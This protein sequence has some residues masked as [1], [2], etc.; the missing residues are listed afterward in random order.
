MGLTSIIVLVTFPR[1]IYLGKNHNTVKTIKNTNVRLIS[2]V[3]RM[4]THVTA[5]STINAL[6]IRNTLD[7]LH[8]SP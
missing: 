7:A 2:I 6:S 3:I 8:F 1:F 5:E 4:I